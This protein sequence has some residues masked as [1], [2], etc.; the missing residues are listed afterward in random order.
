M[1][2][3]ADTY[4]GYYTD[5]SF[6]EH[7]R[8]HLSNNELNAAKFLLTRLIKENRMEGNYKKNVK[9]FNSFNYFRRINY[10]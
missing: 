4:V 1:E 7:A 10:Y 9:M 5:A 8:L 2:Q 6:L 3:V